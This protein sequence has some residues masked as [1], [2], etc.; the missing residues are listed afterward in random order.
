VNQI[1][2]FHQAAVLEYGMGHE[3]VIARHCQF[4]KPHISIITN[5][6]PSH[7]S[8]FNNDIK[9]IARAKSEIIKGMDQD[10]ILIINGDDPHSGLLE[11]DQ[12]KGTVLRIGTNRDC[13]F[14]A[15]NIQHESSGISFD[16]EIIG[17]LLFEKEVDML[18]TFGTNT[19]H[20]RNGAI[21]SGFSPKNI[22]S[23]YDCE[24]LN[25]F[26]EENASSNTVFLFKGARRINLSESVDKFTSYLKNKKGAIGSVPRSV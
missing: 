8:N 15:T 10:G 25:K 19:R 20:Y 14:Q 26:L 7:I 21:E 11:I 9:G 23:F 16:I 2:P 22:F 1:T 24:K 12:F 5:I 18:I 6:G 13:H 3:G 4:I 17:K